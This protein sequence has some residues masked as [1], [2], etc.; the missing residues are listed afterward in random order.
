LR[1]LLEQRRIALA[2]EIS[3]LAKVAEHATAQIPRLQAEADDIERRLARLRK[4]V[5]VDESV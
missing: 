3:T 5:D 4:D 2:S 1:Q